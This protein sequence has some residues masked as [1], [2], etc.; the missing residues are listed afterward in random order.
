MKIYIV[1][2]ADVLLCPPVL[3]LMNMLEKMEIETVLISTQ[4]KIKDNW[5]Y[6]HISFAE[7]PINYEMPRNPVVKMMDM[8]RLRKIIWD[9]I[10]S[11]W[12]KGDLVW[13]TSNTAL[14]HIGNQILE[15]DY[16][17]QLMELSENLKY[18]SA[19]PFEMN[20][21][22]LGNG[23]LAVVVPEYNRAHITKAWWELDHLPLVLANKPNV[24]V[25]FG[26]N[27]DI[28]DE[29][30]RKVFEKLKG[31]KVILYQG[32]IHRERPLDQYIHAVNRLG[33]E[34]A[35][36]VMSGG[37]NIYA[38][39]ESDN[40]YF[41]PY[42]K[43]PLHLQITSNAY[44]GVLSYFP[45]KTDYSI[46]NALYCAPNKTYEYAKFGV[47]MIG[48]DIPGLRYMFDTTGAGVCIE[49]FTVDH[50]CDAIHQIEKNYEQMSQSALKYYGDTDTEAQLREILETV[51]KRMA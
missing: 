45:V 29:T 3:S 31:K 7:L 12:K 26:K 8:F 41:I 4:S 13:L 48:N 28:E 43:P 49:D 39:I 25:S 11:T 9:T 40:Y 17:L 24:K 21:H 32:I 47:P 22:A 36:V 30:A 34:Y 1:H 37:E 15:K 51:K 35:F 16:V 38:D 14:K 19:L 5:E 46:L 42:V 50:I 33:D 6:Q 2:I 23:A 10:N 20:A 27:A 18:H 44:I